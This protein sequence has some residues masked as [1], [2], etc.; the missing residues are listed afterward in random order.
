M[1]ILV[2]AEQR[3]LRFKKSSFETV[4]AARGIAATLGAE[5]TA[6]V[7]GSGVEGIARSWARTVLHA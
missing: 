6:L 3:D 7:V 1:N 4:C 5:V 2:F